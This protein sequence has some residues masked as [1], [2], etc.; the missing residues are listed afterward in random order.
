MIDIILL[1]GFLGAGKT[2]FLQRLLD[3]LAAEGL[4]F[5]AVGVK[6]G[7]QAAGRVAELL[8]GRTPLEPD[9]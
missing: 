7:P 8:R 2:T 1:T 3:A 4:Y 6:S 9:V 5:P